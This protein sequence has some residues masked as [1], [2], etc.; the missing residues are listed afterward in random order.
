M[1][2]LPVTM[3]GSFCRNCGKPVS[4]AARFCP[5][6]G[7]NLPSAPGSAPVLP[8]SNLPRAAPLPGSGPYAFGYSGTD[9]PSP[10][11]RAVDSKAL[12]SVALAAIVGLVGAIVSL[13]E[14]FFTPVLSIAGTANS[15]S[16][17]SVTINLSGLYLVA[18]LAVVGLVFSLLE[19]WL[20]RSAYRTLEDTDDR[21]STPAKLTLLAMISIVLLV[22]AA[23]GILDELYQAAQCAGPGNPITSSCI[24]AGAILGLAGLVV[25]LAI[26][27]FVGYIGL[28]IGIW[29]LGSRFDN[30]LFKAGAILLIF[31]VL[32]LIALILILVAARSEE[33]SL[34]SSTPPPSFV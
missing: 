30:G 6:C 31:P 17:P 32:N 26:I 1:P 18:A 5:F 21:F 2:A 15:G 3:S 28:L 23:L 24:N 8:S 12:S 29:R 4:P 9:R 13:V 14:L 7:T 11:S 27:T 10:A 25:V 16:Q 22:L 19:L 34:G 20:L 33:E